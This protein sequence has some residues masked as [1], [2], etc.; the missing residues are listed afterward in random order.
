MRDQAGC[1][2]VRQRNRTMGK[3]QM[4]ELANIKLVWMDF[5]TIN[6]LKCNIYICAI[7]CALVHI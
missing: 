5:H 2:C 1:V 3:R 6:L 7:R 4:N